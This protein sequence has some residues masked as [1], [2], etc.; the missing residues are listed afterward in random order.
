MVLVAAYLLAVNVVA[1][2]LYAADKRAAARG[3]RRVRESTLLL[4]AAVGGSPGAFAAQRLLRHK[5]RKQPFQ[6][7]FTVLLLAQGVG[8]V[9]GW[10][11]IAGW[12][13]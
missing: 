2:G 9:A 1:Y 8:L 5:T 13:G 6:T 4:V 11:L 3:G 12:L 7:W 10:V